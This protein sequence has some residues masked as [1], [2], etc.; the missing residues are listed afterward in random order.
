V[1]P[2]VLFRRPTQQLCAVKMDIIHSRAFG[3]S[4]EFEGRG[5]L[6]TGQPHQALLVLVPRPAK[7]ATT[8]T[9]VAPSPP[10]GHHQ[11]GMVVVRGVSVQPTPT[12]PQGT[13][14]RAPCPYRTPCPHRDSRVRLTRA[15]VTL[16]RSSA[17]LP[18][19]EEFSWALRMM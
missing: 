6:G 5:T 9:N 13:G 19:T 11:G 1:P 16:L 12:T 8:T 15:L 2:A 7:A 17:T 14:H 3:W 18:S 4:G 10:A